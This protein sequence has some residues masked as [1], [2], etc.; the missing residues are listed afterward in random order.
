MASPEIE[1]Y[2]FGRIQVDGNIYRR[3]VIIKP[4]GVFQDWWRAKGHQ[5]ALGDLAVALETE[6]EVLVIGQGSFSQMKVPTET[7]QH[8]QRA[9]MEVIVENTGAACSTYNRLREQRRVV[10]ALHLSC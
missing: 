3:D 6:P 8:L 2:R 5:L 10:A 9:G 1:D 7:I 4:D